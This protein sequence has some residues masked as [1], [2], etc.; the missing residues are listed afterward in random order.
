MDHLPKKIVLCAGART[1]IGH[2]ARSLAQI[3]PESLLKT[4]I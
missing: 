2:I 4:A 3:T 1:P